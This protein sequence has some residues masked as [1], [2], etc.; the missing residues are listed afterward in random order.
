MEESV[1]VNPEQAG[2]W[3]TMK[4]F[5]LFMRAVPKKVRL[6]HQVLMNK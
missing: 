2:Y 4:L 1:S 3:R 5:E 6:R